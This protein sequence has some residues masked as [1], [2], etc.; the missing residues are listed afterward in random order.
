MNGL[1]ALSNEIRCLK[2]ELSEL[3]D[4]NALLHARIAELEAEKD[5]WPEDEQKNTS[6]IT[7]ASRGAG[8][9]LFLDCQS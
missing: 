1:I 2:N 7:H 9:L 4:E 5:D 6:R 8:G 3:R